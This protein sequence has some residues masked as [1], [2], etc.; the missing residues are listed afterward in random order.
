MSGAR[1]CRRHEACLSVVLVLAGLSAGCV[2]QMYP[3]PKLPRDETARIEV[4]HASVTNIDGMDLPVGS[5]FMLRSGIHTLSATAVDAY[6]DTVGPLTFC[7]TAQGGA[8][9]LLRFAGAAHREPA[10][11]DERTAAEIRTRPL[12]PGERCVPAV[13]PRPVVVTA[14]EPPPVVPTEAATAAAADGGVHTE[15][16][17]PLPADDS[18]AAALP[19]AQAPVAVDSEA[20]PRRR[21]L[22]ATYP[23]RE[24]VEVPSWVRHP[25]NG[26]MFDFGAFLGGTD[27]AT[28][29][30]TDGSTSTVSGGSGVLLSVGVMLTPLW[31]GDG[32]GFGFDAFA[33]VKYDSVGDSSSGSVSLTRYPLGLGAHLLAHIDDR[34]WFI[35]RG[36]IIKEAG[37]SLSATGYNDASLSGSLGGF[38]EGGFYYI[39]HLG[40]DHVAFVFTFRYSASSDSANGSTISANSGGLIVALHVNF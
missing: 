40:D 39:P 3:G 13:H 9:Y 19:R 16:Q 24:Q 32:A 10:L 5:A 35:L 28:A 8:S 14:P 20:P 6:G 12:E 37:V 7:F 1:G 21:P 18:A 30:F 2:V 15:S 33:G 26:L 34:W 4:D 23:S 29:T 38:G 25:G 36:G 27:L 31:A 11:I 17:D 22:R